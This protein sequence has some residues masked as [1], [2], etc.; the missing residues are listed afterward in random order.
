MASLKF[1]EQQDNLLSGSVAAALQPTLARLDVLSISD[2]ALDED[3][4][5]AIAAA[6]PNGS[7]WSL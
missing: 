6:Q 5:R 7:E 2:N 1:L 3:S 4:I